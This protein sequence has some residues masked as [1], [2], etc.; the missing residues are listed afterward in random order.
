MFYSHDTYGLGH[1]RRTLALARF[2]PAGRPMLSQLIVTGSP[3]AHR[4]QLPPRTDYIKLPSVLKMGVETYE[5]RSLGVPFGTLR[6][7][8]EDMLL[9]TARHF[10]PQLLLVDN[11]PRG[12]KGELVPTLRLLKERSCRLVLGL[13][14]VVDEADRVR[15]TWE[16][17]GSYELLENLYDMILVYGRRDVYD[18]V[19]EYSFQARARAKTRF[20]GYLRREPPARSPETLREELG[21]ESG[22]LVLVMAGGGG[23]G[24]GLLR[25]VVEAIRLGG[26][27]VRFDCLLLGGPLMP[28][29]DRRRV[30]ALAAGERF[31]RFVD[32]VDDVASYV[33]AAD[34][35]VS[36]GGYNSVCEVL[37]AGKTAIVVPRTT[38]RREQLI[39]AE[40][41]QRRGLLRMLEPDR[42]TAESLLVEIDGLLEGR[43]P[44]GAR[45]PLDG[46]PAAAGAIDEL[47]ASEP[48]PDPALTA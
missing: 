20:V 8:R 15:E 25:A 3:L 37:S 21:L 6:D 16:R 32:F 46:I 1:L 29:E 14:D 40:A 11:V 36:M 41:L 10:Q 18:V 44:N 24:Y 45:M 17:D 13:R 19:A 28:P 43:T 35:I 22:R 34:V 33:A 23:D 39:R 4:F 38:P 9:S 31:I 48:S 42:L 27:G 2:L 7:L 5:S 12:L 47:L 26:D 30:L